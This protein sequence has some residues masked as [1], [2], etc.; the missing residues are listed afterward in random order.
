MWQW[1]MFYCARCVVCSEYPGTCPRVLKPLTTM[2]C[3]PASD[4]GL[5]ETLRVHCPQHPTNATS[6]HLEWDGMGV[7]WDRRG[8]GEG[9]EWDGSGMGMGEGG[10]K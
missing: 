2:G 10:V 4:F 5:A 7:G 8:M 3:D 1:D 6:T 9:W